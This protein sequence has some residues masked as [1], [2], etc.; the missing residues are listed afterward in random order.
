MLIRVHQSSINF[1][2]LILP[3]H[4]AYVIVTLICSDAV[5]KASIRKVISFLALVSQV[6]IAPFSLLMSRANNPYFLL[7]HSSIPIYTLLPGTPA[8]FK[9]ISYFI[10]VLLNGYALLPACY[11]RSSHVHIPLRNAFPLP[12]ISLTE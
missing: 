5:A 9:P 6:A 4:A 3:F 10:S 7:V 11:V 1:N 8:W 2:V 12:F